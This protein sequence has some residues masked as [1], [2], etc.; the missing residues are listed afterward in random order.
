MCNC[1]EQMG[2]ILNFAVMSG[3]NEMAEEIYNIYQTSQ[4]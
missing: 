2:R 4:S 1:K 3:D